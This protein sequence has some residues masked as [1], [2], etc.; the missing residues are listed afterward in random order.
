MPF[1]LRKRRTAAITYVMDRMKK[2]KSYDGMKDQNEKSEHSDMYAHKGTQ[3]DYSTGY[4]MAVHE[5]MNAAERKDAESFEK[6][7]SGFVSMM[8]DSAMEEHNQLY[9]EAEYKEM[10]KKEEM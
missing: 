2:N 10:E 6:A 7:L 9:H 1:P 8:I 5:L 3:S 4:K